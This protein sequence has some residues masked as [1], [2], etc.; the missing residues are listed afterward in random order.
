MEQV[1]NIGQI[2]Y[3]EMQQNGISLLEGFVEDISG[4]G[5]YNKGLEVVIESKNNEFTYKGINLREYDEPLK[6]KYLYRS[7]SS[8]GTDV[9]PT[10]KVT[11]IK[12][13]FKGKIVKVFPEAIK[14]SKIK[15]KQESDTLKGMYDCILKSLDN[16]ENDLLIK[17]KEIPKK[18]GLFITTVLQVDG[19]RLYVGDFKLFK[20]KIVH[21]A[22]E[23]FHYSKTNKKDVYKDKANCSLCLNDKEDIFGLVSVF[24][25][26]TIDKPGYISGGFDY[27]EAWRNYPV[28]KECAIKLE[29]GKTYLDKNLVFSFYGRKYYLIPKP[30]YTK[31]LS[32]T[33][34]KYRRL[35]SDDII[36]VKEKYSGI[37]EKVIKFLAKEENSLS[38]DL[39]FIESKN[40]ALN[41]LL[42]IEDVSPSRFK[43]IYSALKEI[44]HMEFFEDKK[45]SFQ[46]LNN[47]FPREKYNKY[48]LDVIDG[49]ISDRKIDYSFLMKFFDE[50]IIDAFKRYEKD[51]F[52][53]D[54]DSYNTATFRVFSFLYFLNY[55]NLF[56]V[57]E[58]GRE[59]SLDNKV[60][61]IKDFCNREAMFEDFFKCSNPF[62]EE[63]AKKAVFLTGYLTRKLLSIQFAKDGRKPFL[64]KLR[65]LKLSK[66]DIKRLIPEI[67][68][69][70]WEYKNE[71]YGEEFSLISKYMISSDELK[72]ISDL[73]IPFYFSL[74]MN[75]VDNFTLKEEKNS[76]NK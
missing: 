45:V 54:K 28:C 29:L 66:K 51:E 65:G 34:K 35:N 8:R 1:K 64:S 12:K 30:V 55:L 47:V 46:L 10:A 75:M 40:A 58:G 9:T 21:D 71:G 59:M 37:E 60:W 19:S 6:M 44:R 43:K 22:L 74:G 39:M 23:K 48:F 20:E 72:S 31:D 53:K 13:T 38:Y 56:R 68:N 70:L 69:K 50:Y 63:D 33:L 76:K 26:F 41:I 36:E 7:G 24:P 4:G 49:I 73:D 67:Q 5:R 32:K 15:F 57:K 14:F 11:E 3:T 52:S 18:E 42:N 17:E 2:V 16:I 27:K 25:F 62:F 61:N